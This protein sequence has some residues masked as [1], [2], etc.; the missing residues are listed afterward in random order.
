MAEV[1]GR[2]LRERVA[3]RFLARDRVPEI[4]EIWDAAAERWRGR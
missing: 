3:S 1:L 4:L 2:E